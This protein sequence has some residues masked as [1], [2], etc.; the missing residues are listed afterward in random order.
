MEQ[1]EDDNSGGNGYYK[2][3]SLDRQGSE[4]ISDCQANEDEMIPGESLP[5]SHNISGLEGVGDFSED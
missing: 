5:Q 4:V 2:H 1:D 3:Q